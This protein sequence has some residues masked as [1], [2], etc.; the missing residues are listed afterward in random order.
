MVATTPSL[1]PGTRRRG[2]AA[3]ITAVSASALGDGAFLA[4]LPLAAAAVTGDPTR[5][6]VVTV[7]GYL[8]W[9]V[10]APAAGV[11][12]D[13]WPYRT[14]VVAA[15]GLRALALTALAPAVAARWAGIP[16]LAGIAFVAVAGQVFHDA[17]IQGIVA[18]LTGRDKARLDRTNGRVYACDAAGRNLFGPPAGS[19]SFAALPWVPFGINAVS[20]VV[21]AASL[22]TLPRRLIPS[23][24]EGAR[25]PVLV[26]IK[27]GVVFIAQHRQLRSL[28]VLTAIATFAY[29]TAWAT[30]VLYA[31]ARRGLH[32]SVGGFGLLVAALAMGAVAGGGVAD[33]LT[34]WLGARGAVLAALAVAGAGWLGVSAAPNPWAAG[35]ALAAVGVTN[36]VITVVNASA[37]QRLVPPDMLGRA[38]TA[39][40]TFANSAAPIGAA[41]GGGLAARFGLRSPLIVAG[42][43]LALAVLAALRFLPRTRG[44]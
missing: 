43:V 42:A 33:R 10:I 20:F 39:F 28:A 19:L 24:P 29:N 12:V 17:A 25:E 4:A 15:D 34:T 35:L 6:A 18:E 30:F 27:A 14:T 40:R 36:T 2:V 23:Q 16:L 26:A 8:P 7:A 9:I 1:S 13:R 22:S 41:I 32:V 38:V 21:S 11:L 44:A 5:V 3:V 31:T 37:R